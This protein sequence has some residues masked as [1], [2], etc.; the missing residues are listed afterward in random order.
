[1]E[2]LIIIDAQNDFITGKLAVPGAERVVKNICHELEQTSAFLIVTQD[3][4][5]P[6]EY[7]LSIEGKHLPEHCERNSNGY[8]LYDE[9]FNVL[10][11]KAGH[12]AHRKRKQRIK[13]PPFPLSISRPQTSPSSAALLPL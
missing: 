4:H 11:R 1:M 10:T 5:D 7:A 3:I 2:F 12:P 8:L 6:G 9:L 13:H